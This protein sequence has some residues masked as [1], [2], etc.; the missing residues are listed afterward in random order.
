MDADVKRLCAACPLCV[1]KHASTP[2]HVRPPVPL[3]LSY[4]NHIVAFYLFGPFVP[5]RAGNV[6]V[7]VATGLFMKY[8]Q[9]RASKSA[10]AED[11]VLTLRAWISRNCAPTKLLTDRGTNYTS[12]VL[13]ETA[14]LLNVEEV[15]T[16]AGHKKTNG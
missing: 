11:S 14:R 16:T 5:T 10:K 9:L 8:V 12:E 15:Y 7:E 3:V 1:N 2:P 4:P 6:Y 13:K